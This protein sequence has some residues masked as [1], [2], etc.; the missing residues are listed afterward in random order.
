[1]QLATSEISL[2][3]GTA[4]TQVLRQNIACICVSTIVLAQCADHKHALVTGGIVADPIFALC[5]PGLRPLFLL[6]PVVVGVQGGSALS[7]TSSNIGYRAEAHAPPVSTTL[8]E[9]WESSL[10]LCI[11]LQAPF[12]PVE[13]I[14]MF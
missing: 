1:M 11:V 7:S 6:T 10:R 9:D 3:R 14:D 5:F 13:A 2:T 12:V 8:V 4:A